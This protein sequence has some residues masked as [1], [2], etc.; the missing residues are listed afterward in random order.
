MSE[1][2]DFEVPD[3][4][5]PWFDHLREEQEKWRA[6]NKPYFVLV[7]GKI[8]PA[9]L[10]EWCRWFEDDKLRRVD[11]TDISNEPNYPGGDRISTVCL[12]LDHNHDFDPYLTH[13]PILFETMVFGGEYNNRMWRYATYGEAKIGHWQF[14]D[15]IRA[16]KRPEVNV[17]ERPFIDFFFEMWEE[18]KEEDE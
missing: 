16:G 2:F 15:C 18:K 17:G 12:G 14:V 10:F 6:E 4:L 1:G 3:E 7:N 8:K 13:I 11:L 5:R 9:T